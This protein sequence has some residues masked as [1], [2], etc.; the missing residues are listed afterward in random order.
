M[1]FD[2]VAEYKMKRVGIVDLFT[3][4]KVDDYTRFA[5]DTDAPDASRTSTGSAAG[6]SA[7]K[8]FVVRVDN[9]NSDFLNEKFYLRFRPVNATY[10]Y[11][12]LRA[13]LKSKDS[14]LS[15]FL[16]GYQIM[17]GE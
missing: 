11:L 10:N 15:P 3:S 13:I 12:R 17:I 5:V 2:I 6:T 1:G 8:V 9:E 16:D 4:T 7:L 14:G